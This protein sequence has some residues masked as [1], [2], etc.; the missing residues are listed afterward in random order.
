MLSIE[1]PLLIVLERL[2]ESCIRHRGLFQQ[3][4]QKRRVVAGQLNHPIALDN[5]PRLSERGLN[6]ELTPSARKWLAEMGFDP[7]FGARPLRRALQKHV[8]S[9]LSVKLL[10]GQFSPG[11][12]ILV[13]VDE[14]SNQLVFHEMGEAIPA[15]SLQT[16]GV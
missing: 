9:P 4:K 10:A 5:A 13:E 7:A 15:D 2:A 3:I 16:A 8:E 12:K 6:V 11:D 1:R 14:E